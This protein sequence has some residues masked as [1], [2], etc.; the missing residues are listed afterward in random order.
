MTAIEKKIAEIESQGPN[1]PFCYRAVAKKTR[2]EKTTLARRHRGKT[3]TFA[4]GVASQQLLN[5]QQEDEL[6]KYIQGLSDRGLPPTRTIVKNF[7]RK[8][9]KREPSDL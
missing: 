1:A 4:E 5:P 7:A 9:A 2:V 3:H 8:I 6:V